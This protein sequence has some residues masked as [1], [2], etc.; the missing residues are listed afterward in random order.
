MLWMKAPRRKSW[1]AHYKETLANV[2]ALREHAKNLEENEKNLT[3]AIADIHARH[4][5]Q[6]DTLGRLH[7]AEIRQ[8]TYYHEQRVKNIKAE[9]KALQ[10]EVEQVKVKD[11]IAQTTEGLIAHCYRILSA[12]AHGKEPGDKDHAAI[13]HTMDGLKTAYQQDAALRQA[14]ASNALRQSMIGLGG[15]PVEPSKPYLSE[16]GAVH[17]N[18]IPKGLSPRPTEEEPKAKAT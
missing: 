17:I 7:R 18:E 6:L 3:A 14:A 5:E 4:K 2:V 1:Y 11:E 9:L 16:L 8:V 12:Y 13:R 15:R 10:I